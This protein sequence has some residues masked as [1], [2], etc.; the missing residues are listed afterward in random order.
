MYTI[1]IWRMMRCLRR[2]QNTNERTIFCLRHNFVVIISHLVNIAKVGSSKHRN[3]TGSFSC[4]FL[5]WKIYKDIGENI[6]MVLFWP[7]S[8]ALCDIIC[9]IKKYFLIGERQKDQW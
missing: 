7:H 6:V 4:F 5:H 8:S 1:F 9:D 3:P 2:A